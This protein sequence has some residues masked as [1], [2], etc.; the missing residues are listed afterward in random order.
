[1]KTLIFATGNPNKAREVKEMLGGL[2]VQV[3]TMREAGLALDIEETG[4]TFRENSLIKARAVYDASKKAVL[5]DDSGLEIDF[6]GGAPG[7]YS[8]RFMGEDTSYDIKNAAI[9]EK[10]AGVEDARRTARFVCTLVFIDED[11]L[12]TGV[13]VFVQ[14]VIDH[15]DGITRIKHPK[16]EPDHG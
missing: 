4:A 8:A 2:D 9:L 10:L 13:K 14:F 7:V 16:G 6:L 12:E 11:G 3:L 5:A 1:M 15:M